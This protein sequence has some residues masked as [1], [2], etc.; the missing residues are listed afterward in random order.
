MLAV[1]F[2]ALLAYGILVDDLLPSLGVRYR[3][4]LATGVGARTGQAR[5]NEAA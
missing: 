5:P 4:L 3:V 1:L 2:R